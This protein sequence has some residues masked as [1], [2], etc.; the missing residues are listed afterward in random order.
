[1]HLIAVL[2]FGM[3]LSSLCQ[4]DSEVTS[5]VYIITLKQAHSSHYYGELR[6]DSHGSRHGASGRLNIHAPRYLLSSVYVSFCS[7][8]DQVKTS[9]PQVKNSGITY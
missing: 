4:D 9:K 6:R 2:C 8:C 3:F 5:A 1:M 7:Y